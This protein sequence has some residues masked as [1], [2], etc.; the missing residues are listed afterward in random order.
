M[1]LMGRLLEK[2]TE[3]KW[4][5]RGL[6]SLYVSVISGIVLALQY[7]FSHPFYSAVAQET[8][9]PFGSFWRSLHFYSS[10]LFFLFCLVHLWAVIVNRSIF[11]M[12][13]LKWLLALA[14]LPLALLLLF[15]GYVLR[16]DVTGESAGMIAE[17]IALSIPI[18][19]ESVNNILFAISDEGMKRVYANHL[20]GLAVLWLICTWD[21]LRR[22]RVLV[23]DHGL[24][25][26]MTVILSV[27][28]V[29]PM[30][31]LAPGTHYI[32]G[33]WFFLGLQELLRFIAP[34]GAGVVLPMLIFV[35]LALVRLEGR[36]GKMMAW[37]VLML[38]VLYG[39]ATGMALGR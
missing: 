14:S 2:C 23:A 10:Q 9:I 13:P 33:P 25:L 5:A 32:G 30:E 20:A 35:L 31:V 12:P 1:G 19:G 3:F 21:H 28:L 29:A 38:L 27:I 4:G 26:V 22:Y 18:V 34:F 7:D 6:I 39:G 16:G 15:T 37:T 24:L 11:K 36:T 17:Q 8:L